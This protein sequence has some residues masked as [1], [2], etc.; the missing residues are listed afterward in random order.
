MDNT[1]MFFV[2]LGAIEGA[3]E[4]MKLLAWAEGEKK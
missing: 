2:I 1:T 3:R 4:F